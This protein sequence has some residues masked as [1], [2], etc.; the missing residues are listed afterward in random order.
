MAALFLIPNLL[1]DIPWYRVLPADLPEIISG[2]RYFIA[3]DIRNARRFLKKINPETNIDALHFSELNKFTSEEQKAGYLDPL[4]S[5]ENI[6]LLSE[7]GCPGV[8]D[9]G[10]DIVRI[11]HRHHLEVI[12][13]TGPSSILLGLMASGLNGQHFVFHGYLPVKQSERIKKIQQLEKQAI[14]LKQTQIFI[15]T[16]YRNNQMLQ[17]ILHTCQPSTLL[18]IAADL[19]TESEFIRTFPVSAWKKQ[20]PDIDKRPAVFLLG[21]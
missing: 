2:I 7:A 14:S 4:K 16:P 17:D 10:A 8:A 11:A 1:G 12:P 19:T 21:I 6:G 18:C 13:L 5:G 9:P 15:E 3:E 20:I